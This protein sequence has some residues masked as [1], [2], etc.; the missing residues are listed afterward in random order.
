[1]NAPV[2]LAQLAGSTTQTPPSPKNLK[3]EKPQNGQAISVHLDGN[4]KLDFADIASEK[5][6]FVKVGE[7]LIILFDNQSTVTVDPV[8]DSMGKPLTD[9][10]FDMGS[11][12][13]LTGE[14]FA[15]TFP[16]T[17]D[18]SVLPAA[19]GATGPT[20]GANF[21]DAT[22][23]ALGA[24]GA[25]LALLTGED[26]GGGFDN[27]DDGTPNPSPIP[28]GVTAVTLNEDGF[29]EGNLGGTGDTGGTATSVT[30]S[31]NVDFGTDGSN[32]SFAFSLNQPT[33][34]G[35]TS[36][37][38]TVQLA[39]TTVNGQPV[40]IGY[41]GGDFNVAANQVFTV[42]LDASSLQGNYTFTLLRPLDH[43]IGGTEDTI[44]LSI[45]V[46]ATDGSGDTV[47]V[48]IPIGINDDTPVIGTPADAALTDPLSG[49]P[50]TQTGSL[51]ISWG[52]DRYN[53]HVDGGVSATTGA[54]G[55]RSVVF[56]NTQV[57]A[58]GDGATAIGTL[59]SHGETVRYVLLENGT[60]LVAYTGAT[61]PTSLADL[62]Q[63]GTPSG[64]G[65]GGEG[66]I[67]NNV[68]F[69]VTLSDASNSGSYVV[70]QYR[71]LDHDN[72]S[73]TFQNIDLAFNFTA[74]DSDGDTVNGT[75][76]AVIA[77]TVPVVTGSADASTLSEGNGETPPSEGGGDMPSLLVVG[78]SF[79]PKDTGA[80]S[81]HID[82]RSDNQN[83]NTPGAT[84]DRSVTF[85]AATQTALEALGL[86]SDGATIIY[87]ISAGGT[88]LT[89][90]TAAS[91][92]HSARTIFTVQLSDSGNGSY[93]FTLL[94]NLDHRGSSEGSQALT[95]GFIATDSDGDSTVPASFTVNITD[96]VPTAGGIE[97]QTL[98]E[99]TQSGA[100]NGF[101]STSLDNVSLNINWGA[102]DVNNNGASIDR[103][104]A[105]TT[106]AAPSGLTSN[107]EAITYVLSENGTLLT[108]SAGERVVFT[109]KLSDINSGTYTFTLLDNLDH[110]G[111]NGASIALGFNFTAT[112]ADGDP[113]GSS[114][115]V[116]INDD[117]PTTGAIAGETLVEST[118]AESSNAFIAKALNGISLNV[119]WNSDDANAGGT[120]DRSVAFTTSAAPSGL[121]SNGQT[122]IYTLS[123]NGTLLTAT[124][125]ARTVFTVQL[126]DTG[127]GTYTFNLLDNLDH[128]GANG[129]SV[130]LTFSFTATDSD[131]DTTSPASFTVNVTD[132]SP[133]IGTPDVLT[134]VESTSPSSSNAFISATATG[135][136]AVDWNSDDNNQVSGPGTSD[137]SVAF[138]AA[139]LTSLNALH[140]TSNGTTL[141]YSF[142][143][144]G[145]LLTAKAGGTTVFTVQLSD[146]ANGTYTFK[147]LDNLDHASGNAKNDLALTFGFT[148]TDSDGDTTAPA[149]FTVH[150]TDDVPVAGVGDTRGVDEDDL[151]SGTSPNFF[152]LQVG[153][154]LNIDWNSD[155][156]DGGNVAN[157]S[158]SFEHTAAADNVAVRD[159]N[160]N[161]VNLTSDGATVHYTII[162]E[163]LVAYT[164]NN[165][166]FNRVFVVSLDDDNAG[167]YT[168]TLLG[169]V[170]HPTA[171]GQ[172][173]L[174]F[175]FDYTATDSDGD[176]SSS[177]F[178]VTVKDDVPTI[179]N[180][181]SESV[182]EDSLP[183]TFYDTTFPDAPNSTVQLGDLNI[184]W[185]ADNNNSGATNNRS[186]VFTTA[187]GATG[188]TSDGTAIVYSISADGTV[189]TAKAGVRTVFTVELSDSGD[190]SYKF[191]LF[192]NIDH[193]ASG[194]NDDSRTLS[195]GIKATDSDGDSATADFV[196]SIVD[197]APE[198]H[199]GDGRTINENDLSNGTSPNAPG[200]TAT[201]DL[202]ISWGADDANPSAGGGL[203]DRTVGF[204]FNSAADN[205][206]AENSNGQ[207][208]TLRS[209][210]QTVQYAF[211]GQKLV[212]YIGANLAS[213]TRIFE[214]TLSDANDG[215]YTFKL[216]GNLDHPTGSGTN[217]VN[218]T[219]SY[220]ATDGDGDTSSSNFTVTI[221]D[222]VP[223]IGA[224]VASTLTEDTTIVGGGEEFVPQTA[225]NK[226]LN[227]NWGADDNNSGTANRSVA[228]SSSMDSGDSVHTTGSGSPVLKSDGVTVQFLRIS[229][230]EIWGMANDNGGSLTIN[231]RKVFHITL[232]DTGNGTYTFE[233]LDN[234]DHVG[235]GQGS[236]LSLQL[237]FVATDADG[238][239]D[240]SSFT[241]T[242]SD[243]NGRPSIGTA[244]AVS[245]DEDGLT[246]GNTQPATGDLPG[247]AT[248]AMGSLAISWGADNNN[249]GAADR[250]V[251]FSGISDGQNAMSNVGPLTVDGAQVKLWVVGNTVYGYTGSNPM[252]GSTPPSAGSQVF[253]V[254][255]SDLSSGN[256]TFNLL[257][258]L[259]HPAGNNENDITL[260]FGY[261]ATDADGD[262]T[263][264]STFTVTVNDD[265]PVTTGAVTAATVLD[266]DA[267][268][269]GNAGGAG[270]VTNAT[271]ATGAAGALFSAGADGF[272]SVTLGTTTAFSTIYKDA[273]GVAHQE[274]VTWGSASVSGGVTTWTAIGA[275]S[276]ATVATLAIGA[277]GSY[278]FTT[279]RP[280][281]HP[282]AGANEENLSLTFNYTVTDGD[283][284][285]ATGSLT[286]N[287]N[288][289]TPVSQGT[290]T[291]ATTLDD[292]AQTV[293]PANAGGVSGDVS[294]D[295]NTTSGAAGS[296]FTA[297]ADGFK[298]V[299]MTSATFSVV[300]K[301]A[302]GFA[303]TETATWGSP[304]VGA[305]GATT[306]TATS[307]HYGSAAV[308][309]IGANGS[310]TLT[311][312][313][314]IAHATPGT[315]EE[316]K[317]LTF[318]ITVTDGDGDTAT[319]SLTVNVN[320]DT[321]VLGT[322]V[323]G[324]V[325]EGNLAGGNKDDGYPGDL[326]I[327]Q[328]DNGTRTT[329][330]SLAIAFGADGKAATVMGGT[331]TQ[332]FTF[333]GNSNLTADLIVTQGTVNH[334]SAS[335]I[336]FG[337]INNP[338]II[339][340]ND[341]LPFKLDAI[342]LGLSGAQTTPTVIL[343]GYDSNN[344][345]VATYTLSVAN[346]ASLVSGTPTHFNAAGTP[347]ANVLIDRLE[348]Y[349][350][351][352]FSGYVMADNLV[353]TQNTSSGPIVVDA[354]V[355]FTDH[356]NG[357]ANLVVKDANANDVT[358]SL[359]SNGAAVHYA[360]IDAVTLIGYTGA[361][362]PISLSDARVVFSAVLSSA[363]VNGSYT[364]TQNANLDH[365]IAGQDDDLVFTFNF[366]AKDGDGDKANGHFTVTIDDD[367]PTLTN[368][369][370]GANL[371]DNGQFLDNAGFGP[372]M[373]W[374]GQA[375]SG[376]TKG[377][378]ITGAD[379]E[380]NPSGWY[381]T[382][383]V[384]GGRVVDLDASPGNVTIT[385]TLTNLTAGESYTLS[386]DAAK[387]EG[388]SATAQV[389]WNGQ[390]VG[391][392]NPT[393]SFQ[394]FSF[395]F[396]AVAGTNTLEFR[397]VGVADNGGTFLANVQ[398]HT[399]ASIVD[400][401]ALSGGNAGGQGD[402]PG[403]A[404]ATGSL[405]IHWGADA[406][407]TSDAGGVQDGAG[408][409]NSVSSNVAALTG[410][411]VYFTDSDS[412]TSGL[413]PAVI[414]TAGV[415][416]IA[417]TSQ[418]QAVHYQ[419]LENGT[420]VV[421]Y[422]GTFVAGNTSNW[423]FKAS[424]SDDA[425]GSYKFTLF[426]P[427]DHPVGG[428][429]DDVSLSF[430]YTARDSDGDTVSG[431][432]SVTVDDDTPVATAP[433]ETVTVNEVGLSQVDAHT[434]FLNV[435]WGADKGDAKHL[436]FAKDGNGNVVGPV[437]HSGG[438][439]LA[440]RVEPESAG[441]DNERLIAYRVDDPSK[442]A[443]F[444]ITLYEPGNPYYTVALFGPL[445]HAPGSD[446]L[447]LGFTVVATD[448]DGDALNVPITVS[449]VDDVPVATGTVL[450]ATV[451][452]S[453]LSTATGDLSTGTQAG[454]VD[455]KNGDAGTDD[456]IFIGN[457]SSLVS[458]GADSPGTF[459]VETTGLSSSLT[460]LTSGGVALTYTVVNNT[461]IAWAGAN[462]IFTFAVNAT[463]GA[464]TFTL[465]GPLDHVANY[466]IDNTLV[467]VAA[468]DNPGEIYAVA[469]INGNPRAFEGRL[470]DGDVI[471][472]V[473]NS[474]NT[475][476]NWVLDNTAGGT[477]YPLSIAAHTTIFINVGQIST[478]PNVHFDLT[479]P[480]AP[481]GQ[482]TVNSGHQDIVAAGGTDALTLDLS[483]AITARDG[484]GDTVALHDQ[485]IIT[486]ADDAPVL[487]GS[488]AV[489]TVD[490]TNTP[491][492]QV[493]YGSLKIA[494][495]ADKIG[496]HL[497]FATDGN[498]QPAHPAGLTS[499]GVALDYM[500]RT[501]QYGE[502]QL[503]AF[504][505]GDTVDNPVFIVA[506]SSP[507]NPTY[508]FTLFQNLDHPAGSNTLDLNFTIR[509][510]DGDGDFVDR[511][512][513]VNVTDSVPTI[514]ATT[515]QRAGVQDDAL[516][517]GNP[518]AGDTATASGTLS[519][520]FGA[521][522]NG[523]LSWVSATLPTGGYT[524]VI[525]GN[526]YEIYQLQN[527]VN[528][529]V[530]AVTLDPATGAYT[531]VQ[532]AAIHHPGGNGEQGEPFNLNYRV[533]DG[534]GDY[535]DSYLRVVVGDD[536]PV[537]SGP[538]TQ[539]NLLTNGDFAGGAFAHTESWGQWATDSTGWKITG[540]QLGQTGVQLERIQSGYL[541][542]VT[543][544]GHPM[545]DLAATP[546]DIAISQ[547][548]NGLPVGQ[549]YTLSFEIGASNPSSAGL[550]VY[551]N[552]VLVHTYQ[553]TGTMTV[554][555]LDLTATAGAN[556]VT[557]KEIGSAGDN[558][559]TY[560]ANVS[561]VQA[562]ASLPVFH[563]DIGEDGASVVTLVSGTDFRFGADGPGSVAF[564]TAHATISTPTGT[565]LGVPTLSYDPLTGKLTVNPSWGFNGLSEGEIATLSVPFT[566][567]DSDGDS[568]SGVYQ[569]TIH[570]TN[571]AVT[572]S[573]GFPD[574]GT[575]TEYAETDPQAGSST[576]RVEFDAPPGY[577]GYNGGGFWIY[578]DQ[579]DTHTLTVTPQATG[580][581]GHLTAVVS[582]ET[583][584]DGAGFVNWQY[585]V[586]DADLNPLAAGETKIEKF[587]ITVDDGHGSTTSRVITVT[588]VGTNDSPVISTSSVVVGTII[589]SGDPSGV[590]EAGL[591][592]GLD[593][594]PA[595]A[596]AILAHSLVSNGLA[597]LQADPSQVHAL[598]A[599]IQSELGVNAGTA[600]TIIWNA[601]DDAYVAQGADQIKINQAF[602]RLG[603]EYAAYVKNGGTPLL[604]VVAKYT[605]DANNDGIPERLQSLHD[606]LLGNLSEAALQQRY[607][608]DPL[609]GIF[610]GQISAI[611]PDLLD[612]PYASGNAGSAGNTAAHTW[613][614]ANGFADQI[615]GQLIATD[616]DHGATQAW[617]VAGPATYGTMAI[618]ATG[619]WTYTLDNTLPATQALAQGDSVQ[620]T[621]TATVTDD[622]GAT[623]TVQV[624]V[625]ITGSNDAPVMTSGAA[626]AVV[627]E[628]GGLN[629]VVTAEV[630]VDHKFE[631][632]RDVDGVADD[633]IGSTINTA[634]DMKAVVLAVQATLGA[635]A[636]MADAIAA[637]W[638]YLDD[639]R[640][641]IP[642]VDAAYYAQSINKGTVLLGLVYGEYL[643]QGGRPLLDV[644][645]KYQPDGAL[646]YIN[647]GVQD[648]TP[649]RVQSMHD[650]LLGAVDTPSID[651]KFSSDQA[652]LTNL[653]AQILAVGLTDRPIYSGEEG[654][655]NNAL[656]W[657]QA[658][659]FLPVA[660]GQM[661]ATDVDHGAVLTWSINGPATYGNM[662]IDPVTGVWSYT[663][664]NGKTATQALAEG[665]NKT[666]VFTA[667]VTDE[668]GAT[669]NQTVTI[670]IHGT[671]DAPV[672][673]V[674]NG[675]SDARF[676]TE[677]NAALTAGGTLSV[678]DVDVS[679]AVTASVLSVSASGSGIE[680]HFTSAQL[681][682]FLSLDA[683]QVKAAGSTT[684]DIAWTFNSQGEA[685]DFLPNGWESKISYTI[686]VSDGHGGMDTHVVEI[687]IHGTN[688]APV[689]DLDGAASAGNDIAVTAVEQLPQWI[690]SSATITD[691]DSTTMH[692]MKVTLATQ[693]DGLGVEG[694]SFN[695][696]TTDALTMAGLTYGY[697][698][699][700][701]VL[702]VTGDASNAVYQ[703]IMR[704]VVYQYT[705]DAPS[706]G[707]RTV[708]VVVNDGLDNS[709]TH[710]ATVHVLPMNDA[711]SLA[712]PLAATV[713]EGGIHT[714]T[715]TE[716]GYTD[717]D[718]IDS[719]VV[720][721]V[722]GVQHGT[723]T[724]GGA[725]ATSFTA[726]ELAAGLIKFTHDG[727]DGSPTTF[728][729]Y[730]EDGNQDGSTPLPGTF[731][732]TVNG[733][734]DAPIN[735]LPAGP[736]TVAEDTPLAITGLSISD[737]DA[738][739][740]SVTT[741][742]SVTSGMLTVLGGSGVT[743]AGN[744]SATVT[745]T[746][747]QAD[748]NAA[749]AL[750]NGVVYQDALNHNGGV[751][752]TVT[753]SDLG[754][755][756]S[757]GALTD[758]DT[759][760]INVTPVND[761][762]TP[763]ND[764]YV[765]D[766]DHNVTFNVLAN[767]TDPD[768]NVLHLTGGLGGFQGPFDSASLE[769]NGNLTVRPTAN[770]SGTV[771]LTYQ[772][773]DGIM[774]TQ[775]T[776]TV[777]IR[778][779]AD[780]AVLTASGGNEDSTFAVHI[781]LHDTDGSEKATHIELSGYPAGTT[782]NQG[783]LQNGVWVI[784]NPAGIDLA[785]LTMTPPSNYNGGFNLGVSVTV[786][787][788]AT[789]TTGLAT[790]TATSTGT[791]AVTVN[792]V[793]DGAATIS[794][795][796]TTQTATA[797]KIGDVLQSTLGTDP[798]GAK[799][800]VVY[801]W[802]SDG[803]N[804][805]NATSANYTIAAGD[806]GHAISVKV[807]YTD[808]QGF[809]EVVTSTPTAAVIGVNH[810]PVLDAARSVALA[811][812]A[813]QDGLLTGAEK[814]VNGGFE[815]SLSTGW[816]TSGSGVVFTSS[817]EHTGNNAAALLG[818]TPGTLSQTFATEIGQ[819][820]VVTYWVASNYGP[821]SSNNGGKVD[822]K[823][824]G[825]SVYQV[826]G[827]QGLNGGVPY[828]TEVSTTV[829]ATSTS[830]TLSF[831]LS[832]T[833]ANKTVYLDDVTVKPVAIPA[834][835]GTLVS[836]LV[837]IGT[838]PGN[839]TDVDAGAT[840]GIA[841]TT[842]ANTLSFNGSWYYQ[843]A[844]SSTWVP[845]GNVSA[846]AALLLPPDAK[847]YFQ[848]S[849]SNDFGTGTITFRAWDQTSGTVGSKADTTV[850]GNATA[851]STA[852]DTASLT[853]D[854]TT[855]TGTA[856]LTRFADDVF[857]VSGSH[858]VTATVNTQT[859]G[860][861]ATTLN[862]ADLVTGAG[863]DTFNM[864][865]N[866]TGMGGS[867]AFNFGTMGSSG[868][869]FTG[870]DRVNVLVNPGKDVSLTFGNA[871]ILSNQTMTIDG[872]ATTSSTKTF[873]V[874]ASLV[875]NGGDFVFVAGGFAS[876]TF[877]GG[878][879][880]D[881][882]KFTAT[883][884]GVAHTVA[885]GAGD[886][887]IVITGNAATVT[888]ADSAFANV[889]GVEHLILS[890]A[891][892]S[893]TLGA[894]AN[895]DMATAVGNMLIIDG[896]ASSASHSLTVDASSTTF[897]NG[898]HLTVIGGAGNDVITGSTG[899]DTL[900][901]GLGN[902]TLSGRNGNDT[903]VFGLTDGSND[904]INEGF[905]ASNS[906]FDRIVIKTGGAAMSGLYAFDNSTDTL[907]GDLVIQYN[908]QQVTV[909]GHFSTNG[910]QVELINFDGG[911][912]YGY[913]LGSNDYTIQSGIAADPFEFDGTRAITLSSGDNF[914]AGEL[915]T[916]N[917]ITGGTG[918][919]LI[920]GGSQN[921]ILSG[922][923]G[924]DL[925]VGNAG[926]D[927][928]WGGAGNDVLVGGTGADIFKFGANEIG[929]S[930]LDKII[931]F[932]NA[933]GDKIDISGLLDSIAGLQADGSN[934]NNY[935]H[936]T[937]NGGN[938]LVQV[939]TTGAGNFS[940]NTHD[941]ATLVG[942]GTSNADIVNMVFK[943]TDHTMTV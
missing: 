415:T 343:K 217:L 140:L 392:V 860:A 881:T 407:D 554:Q 445:D 566:V 352:G 463:T 193:A 546:G 439:L 481:G 849:I 321:V 277:N 375:A 645:V 130:P 53:D 97:S 901:G 828:Y 863:H 603:I 718:N 377:W 46:I 857:Y 334:P 672:I 15:Q 793:N 138:S 530:F 855:F 214:V 39:F 146:T 30:G 100:T 158:V 781:A 871:N 25:R 752:L 477:D 150:V 281:V 544:N 514:P 892:N 522:S 329:S 624:T 669:A 939:D 368:P 612:R 87:T 238:D 236:A 907:Y 707:D 466:V 836:S 151:L 174:T 616:V 670:T 389:W 420:T 735:T 502:K 651:D 516:I 426:K 597:V 13:T 528:V 555:T 74:T 780:N 127:N 610:A 652:L 332:T 754:Y 250:S 585:H 891:T 523:H 361:I 397:E 499:D 400:E 386:F 48:T 846:A 536:V 126:S 336:V 296:L 694:L 755:S 642:N 181:E 192:D 119:D 710:T 500:L 80:V 904:R 540:T 677:T 213:G 255:L 98:S 224:P 346:V 237:G 545:V 382:D 632:V 583:A 180:T 812:E 661:T 210:G 83:P 839:V 882:F 69:V 784:D 93:D 129:A 729:V 45:N 887:S 243:D 695:T 683:S 671:N 928:L 344:N 721:H 926:G 312:N 814:A 42:S 34:A 776:A 68:V 7:K 291:A 184:N 472:S 831:V 488:A 219:F 273:N 665:E 17:T 497:D 122:I 388:F 628:A 798:D 231:D 854:T 114:F 421:G 627:F 372:A 135:S 771:I 601:L 492:A 786:V 577:G 410:R 595:M 787:D 142:S 686:Q 513:D 526:I 607:G 455:N 136:L 711:P 880:D 478:P 806:A 18:Q 744:G 422:T 656:A 630:A 257:K 20:G 209:D 384:N 930:N 521:D 739:T 412:A 283:N 856:A 731:T 8:F 268:A 483:S 768:G 90:T 274:S 208:L 903:Y 393:G 640:G 840:T 914:V 383:P 704:G 941:V 51:G 494:F 323:A 722:S 394:Q 608:A 877:K 216:L 287:V 668:H 837:G 317:A 264:A 613:D 476:V 576:D 479:G 764:V 89:A 259:D 604:D 699:T 256:Y 427:I 813:N 859:S 164:G 493:A 424:L 726:A 284:D 458:M 853:L 40:L 866:T 485:L 908:G 689:V 143:D 851:F 401:D 525:N 154:R 353:V 41:V 728:Q 60:V 586:T 634:A 325:D 233:L 408:A 52:A 82:W 804:I 357:L 260:S 423:V 364:F 202:N 92:G 425:N 681:L 402:A 102:D 501:T 504:K 883:Q 33:L 414:A 571:D 772:V 310:Y 490:E 489:V 437:L 518:E 327:A 473:T 185:G 823:L 447:T 636:T 743:I 341:S 113:V 43:P 503:V 517:N 170:D 790:D 792:A 621:F 751:D 156:H 619:K 810:A 543:S 942:Y 716:L 829:T 115:T 688:D 487:V 762:P 484:D 169:H 459:V 691:V 482:T 229:D 822:L 189:L 748:I 244:Q 767:D 920:F 785:H 886:D 876:N 144:N 730:V 347:F 313:A 553:P 109:V 902:D 442:S 562:S 679:D 560:L 84:H 582:E 850:N 872:S 430:G 36:D 938:V 278:T 759:I 609:H 646:G 110:V 667:T 289:D 874:D 682:S 269:G 852:T 363:A 605:A 702:T 194:Q 444:S 196:V 111:A 723:I 868:G 775:A 766:E 644:I 547:T 591:G 337:G 373:G 428:S 673:H 556:T 937:Q 333:S 779:V 320:D 541:G 232:S 719:E 584:N 315:A 715:A 799:T 864:T 117:V 565:T 252:N 588:L 820:Y 376:A 385:Q 203:G 292:E 331:S 32:R 596:A 64:E 162:G 757:G 165:P 911:S 279:S 749:L 71:S 462:Q 133:G 807:T 549:H 655:A 27:L 159:V 770:A 830:T 201:G 380:R 474:G 369:A 123:D 734:N 406:S 491:L 559:G 218:L 163:D 592:G 316:N 228:F 104:V 73:A 340:A 714:L 187:A 235:S 429:E 869:S 623:D 662:A 639:A 875:T 761:A 847:I 167:S 22:V 66:G 37:G 870:F 697:D 802:L 276:G 620:Q 35:L 563:A 843:L 742:L 740:S 654:V 486:V 379:L 527:S 390:L 747:S 741:T 298:S 77:D 2:L 195:F 367:A 884:F 449:I 858:T 867:Y 438:V 81:L 593:P 88:L 663:L 258:H 512:I 693:P 664:D 826:S 374:G 446:P 137:R 6:T 599:T 633:A 76:H 183:T 647:G 309:V 61:A 935:V 55:D 206:D 611:D 570:G 567:T 550:E 106:A 405:G 275:V 205:V 453:E 917:K 432:F 465:K 391:T 311:V 160:N 322:A 227:I 398:L 443:V 572:T 96:D 894:N 897:T 659:G 199:T 457:L 708:T 746:G 805:A 370:P 692:S 649:D 362:A 222:D 132:D 9:L 226:S 824:N 827:I 419:A 498:G 166:F 105:F 177:V 506:L 451:H 59:T 923:G 912:V 101:V 239:T 821:D 149:S 539:V 153:G 725:P 811:N 519:H 496:T 713:T 161:L 614:V 940:G 448:A 253:T 551:W 294:P 773:T 403:T 178:S 865:V 249:S 703:T 934:I 529:K 795:T 720:F 141:T 179:G 19:G 834:G 290:V 378:V 49:N 436:N 589:E 152:D 124:A 873:A 538:L 574:A 241:V 745:L 95:F 800:N 564:D 350:G 301:D 878:A 242:I 778:P 808:G 365:P 304:V 450:I 285:P 293:F 221:R 548:I 789:L 108:A 409:A 758:T 131:G 606:N 328:G 211:D 433:A 91:E 922:G 230:T 468:I 24:S 270:D 936:L 818:T 542:V 188:L 200:L 701:G 348:I 120:N 247:A 717:P 933:E 14:Q 676:L 4:T 44:N 916:A 471:I 441:S 765:T 709:I 888:I 85:T 355:T 246:G 366:T 308:L 197:D 223:E 915:G 28:G 360:M 534:D 452:E 696:S 435:S 54:T 172:N 107:G 637:V 86:T 351:N 395:T 587:T 890:D 879:G 295:T 919:D 579:G 658:H 302:N 674:D 598:L 900:V 139:T 899:N 641:V 303:L 266:D 753:T 675:D 75:L 404:I 299:A 815:S 306:W 23:G 629:N 65:E 685:F 832:D 16:I 520:N 803:V 557:F 396:T 215:S 532:F 50:A 927:T 147:L 399:S 666:Q 191:T 495:G 733:V 11:D 578:D 777:D 511:V 848:Q 26:T 416:A 103:K 145:Q 801:Q 816:T 254:S 431:T 171:D 175:T 190:G 324:F 885:G 413:Q 910:F 698:A 282:T 660:S 440:Y 738:G 842:V 841:I 70:T 913:N 56:A 300:Y 326:T 625:T 307:S 454:N 125:G 896:S 47:A 844:G 38:Q 288:D 783:T 78:G 893:V 638:D 943:N 67:A 561:L 176:K 600:I 895:T 898:A 58:T 330:G 635:G 760:H 508:I 460:S 267:F 418:G 687:K 505:V 245:V 1:M 924:N 261:Q 615:S 724:N 727:S 173:T 240:S 79:T 653:K 797:P 31:L 198:A 480:G 263:A 29:A 819:Q 248:S 700:T 769:S 774:T 796:D 618:D 157:R 319:G 533:T 338:I 617:T 835:V 861:S 573:E 684:G 234:L 358:A 271:S 507:A 280:L 648:G 809:G 602:T 464:Y 750:A 833:A 568:K 817:T 580:Y 531:V 339:N 650:N 535:I 349:T 318:N 262:V 3:L 62:Q 712:G 286:V 434:G 5:L 456:S 220:T 690:L 128:A 265:S 112:D 552:G 905:N 186:V 94:D 575:M 594:T 57:T 794:V 736:L 918:N 272:K 148:A 469:A 791:I 461:L 207:N 737:S 63:S 925:L 929:A 680:N 825:T 581:L 862:A 932:S 121:T 118:S 509:A 134:L 537:I 12:R 212:G 909:E 558:T 182:R 345:L 732:F 705:G 643:Q 417:L 524:S 356:S 204:R 470:P 921:D 763:Q 657:D 626:S 889:T 756:G 838:G 335:G 590:N 168:F 569:F 155:D 510:T 411:A 359:T 782:F 475:A 631:P 99:Q 21:G 381:V 788:H 387:P 314:P 931:D 305:N 225:L 116:N 342:D 515:V 467:P 297:G 845:F 10:A 622:H 678:T 371:I 906:D 251:A 706:T 354:A 72:G